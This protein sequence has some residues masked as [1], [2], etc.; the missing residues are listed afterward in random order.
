MPTHHPIQPH[1]F[2]LLHF[3]EAILLHTLCVLLVLPTGMVGCDVDAGIGLVPCG[4][5]GVGFG[6]DGPETACHKVDDAADFKLAFC[7]RRGTL[8]GGSDNCEMGGER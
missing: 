6:A 8:V 7:R 4:E 3:T 2:T 5:L 1:L